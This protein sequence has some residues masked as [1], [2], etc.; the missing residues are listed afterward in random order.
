MS[1]ITSPLP[2]PRPIHSFLSKRSL[3]ADWLRFKLGSHYD[4]VTPSNARTKVSLPLYLS[5]PPPSFSSL[6]NQDSNSILWST[7][8]PS[9]SLWKHHPNY[10]EWHAR[11]YMDYVF[12]R[13]GVVW[14]ECKRESSR[15]YET[16]D[17]KIRFQT[18]QT[19]F[20]TLPRDDWMKR[21]V[22][23]ASALDHM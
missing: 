9:K 20:R 18:R 6:N 1:P 13:S 21:N 4:N 8:F 5:S 23:E 19:I 14:R 22:S 10:I 7:L 16:Q 2:S 12:G 11:F 17:R 15:K 3:Q